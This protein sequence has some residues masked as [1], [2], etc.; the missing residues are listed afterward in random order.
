[1]LSAIVTFLEKNNPPNLEPAGVTRGGDGAC[2]LRP[3]PVLTPPFRNR[4]ASLACHGGSSCYPE[5]G[6][7]NGSDAKCLS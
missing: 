5:D 3:F 1:M 2:L 6:A 4:L 7:V